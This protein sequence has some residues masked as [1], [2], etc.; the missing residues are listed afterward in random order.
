MLKKAYIPYQGYYSTPFVKWQGS[1]ANEN[2]IILSAETSKRWLNF[3]KIDPNTF[4]YLILGITVGQ[5]AFF[6]GSPWAAAMIG[7]QNIPG[8]LLTQACST[9]TTG[10]FQAA[11]GIETE[12]YNH[13]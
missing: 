12:T 11:I 8:V 1:L 5:P 7:A 9:S 4:D 2:S 10:I 13:V 6:Y 3:K